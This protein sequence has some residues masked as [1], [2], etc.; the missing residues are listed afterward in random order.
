MALTGD[1]ADDGKVV[2]PRGARDDGRARGVD[3][4]ALHVV[5]I[6]TA[7]E[8]RV[9]AGVR[10][11]I[12]LRD[13]PVAVSGLE[14][15][16]LRD[17]RNVGLREARDVDVAGRVERDRPAE[18]EERAAEVGRVENLRAVGAQLGHEDVAAARVGG[19]AVHDRE[20]RAREPRDE[21]AAVRRQGQAVRDVELL[22]AAEVG[23]PDETLAVLT[24]LR[25]E[26]VREAVER[27]LGRPRRDGEV[28][29]VRLACDIDAP[30]RIDGDVVDRRLPR[31]AEIGPP[32]ERGPR[33]RG[34][35]GRRAG[36][37]EAE[38]RERADRRGPAP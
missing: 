20:V 11:R 10:R 31:A 9:D 24:E 27:R 7:E 35:R 17:R 32:R 14:R 13:V 25:D 4:D 29:R 28:G 19:V 38:R 22:R 26:G 30:R 33:V 34:G 15:Q 12:D 36:G 2:A 5:G 6:G 23:R 8:R 21:D 37:H 3:G 18:V 1:A 16:D